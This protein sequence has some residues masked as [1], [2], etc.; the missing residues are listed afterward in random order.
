[1]SILF[2][3]IIP[4]YNR[5]KLLERCIQSVVSQTYENWEAIVVDNYSNDNTEEVVNS[6]NDKRIK[7]IKNHNYGIIAVSRN[8]ALDI[9]TGD[10]ICFLD[11][12]D[13]WLSNKLERMLDFVG[14]YDLI[15]H[16]YRKNIERSSFFQKLNCFF[17]EIKRPYI[18]YVLLKGDPINPSC[19][20]LSKKILGDTRFS[21]DK[22]LFACED[23]D[24]FLKILSK[25]I[26]VKYLKEIYTLYDVSGCSHVEQASQ[27]DLEI[28]KRWDSYLND[29]EKEELN[30]QVIQRKADFFRSN[31]KFSEA[32]GLYRN[33]LNSRYWSRR[34]IGIKGIIMCMCK[35]SFN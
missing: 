6:F 20:C 4:T 17:Y 31:S 18:P 9:A 22:E 14:N 25:D 28:F 12:D 5:A 35:L 19:S 10:W 24:F 21:E 29:K 27:R 2:S 8:K 32:I 23:Y 13:C 34:I 3:I 7:Y 26:R 15:Y 30:Y 16:G 33:L 11:S 1:M